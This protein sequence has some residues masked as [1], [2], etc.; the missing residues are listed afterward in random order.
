MGARKRAERK[1]TD[2]IH[3][4]AHGFSFCKGRPQ[5]PTVFFRFCKGAGSAR[6]RTTMPPVATGDFTRGNRRFRTWQPTIS[7]AAADGSARDGPVMPRVLPGDPERGDPAARRGREKGQHRDMKKHRD[8]GQHYGRE[9]AVA[10]DTATRENK[11]GEEPGFL[12]SSP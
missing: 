2:Y 5:N 11:N 1:N 7:H 9:N 10:R 3:I 12:G 4:I 6:C 8:V